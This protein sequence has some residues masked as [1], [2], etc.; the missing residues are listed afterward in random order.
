MLLPPEP[1]FLVK[2]FTLN[3]ASLFTA[4]DF[5]PILKKY[6]GNKLGISDLKKIADELTA[7]Y[8]AQ[9]YI[10]SLAY[11]PT[12]EISNN[13][14]EFKIV[15]GRVGDIEVEEGKY[16]SQKRVKKKFLVKKGEILNS[17][18]IEKSINRI[19]E[20]PDR[21]LKVILLPGE[22]P[23]TSNILLKSEK[24]Q[25]PFHFS[26]EYNNR[27]TEYTGENRF[28]LG[29]VHNN[30]FKHCDI[31]STKFQMAENS[32]IY[33]VSL[34]YNI[35]I[36]RY[37]TRLGLYGSHSNS[38]IGG[39]FKI[40]TPEGKAT[41]YGIYLTHPWFDKDFLSPPALN[42]SGNLTIGLD[43]ISVYNQILGKETSHDE[44][45]VVKMGV[46]FNEKD[47]L[48]RTFMTNEL[49]IG[50][51]NALGSMDENDVKASR[52]DAGGE[53]I[54]YTASLTRVNRFPFSILLVSSVKGQVTDHALVNSEQ[55][56]L[57]GADSIRGFPENEYLA[58]Y[59]WISTLEL[60]TPAFIFPKEFK[61]PKSKEGTAL[62]DAMQ[63]VYF[64]DLGEGF[65]KNPR[66]GE[67]KNKFLVGAGLGLRFELYKHLRGR[68]DWAFPM[69]SQEPSDGS[70]SR[71]HIGVEAEF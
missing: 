7:F 9:G 1:K 5:E 66:V 44:L 35:P 12:Q 63:F 18:K 14:V 62:R 61:L 36:S 51:P 58:D 39:Q 46:G 10:T 57:G 15:E 6:R 71:V 41:A 69:G 31:L 42:L 49:R 29:F 70:A 11:S 45:R 54:K 16:Y 22:K 26:L 59:G 24:E 60:R 3:G 52:L 67:E 55:L 68:I 40:L 30:L 28:G 25:R 20:Q 50:L 56:G 43:A 64:V 23:G 38:E 33:A 32:D 13:T 2:E 21:T 53:F 48:G 37:N 8:R 34:D 19:N 17:K 65:L 47:S 27:G 4:E